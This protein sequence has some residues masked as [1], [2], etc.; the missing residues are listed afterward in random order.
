MKQLSFLAL[1][2]LPLIALKFPKSYKKLSKEYSYV[3]LGELHYHIEKEGKSILKTDT[4]GR[5]LMAQNEVTNAEYKKFLSDIKKT[6]S[7]EYKKLLPDTLVWYYSPFGNYGEVFSSY[8]FRHSAYDDYPVVGVSTAQAESYCDWLTDQ[9]NAKHTEIKVKARLPKKKEWIRAARGNTT[10][11]YA[12]G[13]VLRNS[14]G[15]TLYNFTIIGDEYIHYNADSLS[16]DLMT[17][18]EWHKDGFVTTQV[19]SYWPNMWG[20]YNICGNVAELISDE[21][22][23]MG[24]AWHSPGYDIHVESKISNKPSMGT[25]FRVLLEMLE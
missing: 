21:D 16:F 7:V 17:P 18:A 2:C 11:S 20:I 13:N 6:N 12:Q 4:A 9:L 5:F 8:Y 23:A 1:L 14:K 24:G 22:I 19:G 3:P 25:G 10:W 15:Q